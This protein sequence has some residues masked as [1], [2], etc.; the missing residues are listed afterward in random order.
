MWSFVYLALLWLHVVGAHGVQYREHCRGRGS[1]RW[2]C[3]HERIGVCNRS[4]LVPKKRP[5]RRK[6]AAHGEREREGRRWLNHACVN[7][8]VRVPCNEFAGSQSHDESDSQATAPV[9]MAGAKKHS[10][11]K[12]DQVTT[13]SVSILHATLPKK[14]TSA[15]STHNSKQKKK[16]NSDN[17]AKQTTE[18]SLEDGIQLGK[19]G[20]QALLFSCATGS[21]LTLPTS[22]PAV[23]KATRSANQPTDSGHA[24]DKDQKQISAEISQ[25]R[26]QSALGSELL[27]Q[28]RQP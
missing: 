6:S 8:G 17:D 10:H 14:G 16:S 26:C 20:C 4:W 12:R 9:L 23:L 1:C 13:E 22:P 5:E 3:N 25:V 2:Q 15:S 24:N 11:T 19:R 27:P 7:P 21:R 18:P 28:R